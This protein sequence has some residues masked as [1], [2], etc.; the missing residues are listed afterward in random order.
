VR[1]GRLEPRDPSHSTGKLGRVLRNQGRHAGDAA[2]NDSGFDAFDLGGE[3]LG[4][5]HVSLPGV[6]DALKYYIDENNTKT[7]HEGIQAREFIARKSRK[8]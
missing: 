2:E 1:V 3:L 4:R 8:R 6:G 7:E 5:T